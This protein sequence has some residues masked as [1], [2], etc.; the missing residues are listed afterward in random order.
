MHRLQHLSD[1]RVSWGPA[2]QLGIASCKL[3]IVTHMGSTNI[4]VV[5]GVIDQI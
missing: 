4:Y 2:V 5:N 3:A 1:I